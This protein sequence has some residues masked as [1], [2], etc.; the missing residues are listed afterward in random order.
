MIDTKHAS[1]L[2]GFLIRCELTRSAIL[3][4]QNF[5]STKIA[6]SVCSRRKRGNRTILRDSCDDHS[7]LLLNN[8]SNHV[9][10]NKRFQT[11]FNDQL[12]RSKAM[13]SFK[14]TPCV[15]SHTHTK[16]T[17]YTTTL[18]SVGQNTERVGTPI[19]CDKT[20]YCYNYYLPKKKKICT[21]LLFP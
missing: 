18:I 4:S 2:Y 14:L 6:D 3:W 1:K 17:T 19:W 21:Y 10:H 16:I 13:C 11:L 5:D 8:L 12:D 20:K 15:L 9:F 7:I